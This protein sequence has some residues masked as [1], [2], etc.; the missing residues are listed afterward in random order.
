MSGFSPFNIGSVDES[1]ADTV[2]YWAILQ[3]LGSHLEK[4]CIFILVG[5]VL[6]CAHVYGGACWR[7]TRALDLG[8]E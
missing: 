8:L 6:V 1:Q 7:Q 2:S 5:D 3:I 4:K